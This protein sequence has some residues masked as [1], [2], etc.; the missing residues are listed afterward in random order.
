MGVG[1]GPSCRTARVWRGLMRGR[2]VC[3]V[4]VI[5]G[6]CASAAVS[7]TGGGEGAPR[8]R[9]VLSSLGH[10]DR[11]LSLSTS[12]LY[13]KPDPWRA[14]LADESTCPG[15][16]RTDLPPARQVAVVACLVNFARERR[17]LRELSVDPV[18]NTASVRKAN[19]I[20]R[21]E[22]FAHNP[23]GGDWA[24]AVKSTGYAGRFG[25]NLYIAS[26]RW[27]APRVAVDA[28]LNSRSHRDNLFHRGWQG[29]GFAL[30]SRESFDGY[31]NVSLWVSE[32]GDR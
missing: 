5:A 15:G 2:F 21:C 32:L 30:I 11:A 14:F 23:C 12:S 3:S 31:Q 17:G 25:E 20:I 18:L 28:W 6:L 8:L 13:A 10:G 1:R 29:Q 27:G 9:Q 26:G 22:S 24:S 7:D 4:L 19:A 16:E